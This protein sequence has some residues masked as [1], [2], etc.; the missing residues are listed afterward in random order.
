MKRLNFIKIQ[1]DWLQ[2]MV[3][4]DRYRNDLLKQDLTIQNSLKRL[5]SI[6]LKKH[7]ETLVSE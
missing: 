6:L 2:R 4:G 3:K 7:L 5:D 1:L